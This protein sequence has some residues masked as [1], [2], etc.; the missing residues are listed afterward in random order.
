MKSSLESE[1]KKN[2]IIAVPAPAF[3]EGLKKHF[4]NEGIHVLEIC[5]VID[6]LLEILHELKSDPSMRLDGIIISSSIATKLSDKRLEFLADVLEK[7]RDEFSETSIIY[8]SDESQG[9]PLLAELVSMGIYNIFVKSSKKSEQLNIKQLIQCIDQPMLYS[10]VKKY[11]DYDSGIA[12][13]RDFMNGGQAITINIESNGKNPKGDLEGSQ[14]T[15]SDHQP[16][17][18]NGLNKL[19]DSVDNI[20]EKK[21]EKAKD[22]FTYPN[23]LEEELEDSDWELP[24]LKPKIVV[25]ERIIGKSVIAV[26]GIDK[27]TGTTHSAILIANY[28]ATNG[29]SVK[30]IE[31]SGKDEFSY[32]EKSYDGKNAD[33]NKLDQFEINDVTYVKAGDGLDMA[34][35]LTSEHTHI[36]L[37]LGWYDE[38]PNIEE[39]HRASKQVLVAQGSEWK[40]YLIAKFIKENLAADQSRWIFLLPLISD[41]SVSDICKEN[42]KI[43][44]YN[45]PFHPDP[46]ESQPDTSK[47][48]GYLFSSEKAKSLN[49]AK[50]AAMLIALMLAVVVLIKILN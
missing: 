42:D 50:I 28:L 37:D 33:T 6:H 24:P 27:G 22:K 39:F 11:R 23:V 5:V 4:E 35:Q 10:E 16:D 43:T 9:H 8:L 48:L 40:Q 41:Q 46:F 12:W 1:N 21:T 45:I 25:Q 2:V 31:C 47:L 3:A 34:Y 15:H 36:V 13:R 44:A 49:I 20:A 17:L 18:I 29:Y 30:L 7:I 26:S 19:V 38:T 32:I 14:T